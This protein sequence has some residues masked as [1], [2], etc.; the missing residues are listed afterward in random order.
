M[1]ITLD[2]VDVSIQ[3][4][5]ILHGLSGTFSPGQMIGII[6]PNGSGKSTLL[7]T[8]AGIYRHHDGSL[9]FDG[10]SAHTLSRKE[11][12]K[13]V[14]YVPQETVIT[15]D[16]TVR[17]IVQMGRHVHQPLFARPSIQDDQIVTDAMRQTNCLHLE[18]KKVNQ[19]S[20]G[21]RQLAI[22]AKALAQETPV[23]LLDE[24]IAALDIYYQLH[25]LKMLAELKNRGK[26]VII[27]LHDLN[28]AA[29]FC[30]RLLLLNH[31]RLQQFDT[32]E[33][34]LTP[35]Q[36]KTVYHVETEVIWN[37]ALKSLQVISH[38]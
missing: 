15:V 34:V 5:Q 7:K 3:K 8:I 30:D 28:L 17:E 31:G 1:N 19:L 25:I 6:G 11:M 20:G 36:L 13:S 33:K 14:S 24:P 27:V 29:R 23:L 35:E 38:I 22:I 26:T 2:A 10:E 9:T 12:A 37:H 18:T 4:K 21:Q 32:T 16:F